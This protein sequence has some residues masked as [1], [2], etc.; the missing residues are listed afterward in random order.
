MPHDLNLKIGLPAT[1]QVM[2]AHDSYWFRL[3]LK[4][5]RRHSGLN[6]GPPLPATGQAITVSAATG[7]A[8]TGAIN[9]CPSASN[10]TA[11]GSLL[12]GWALACAVLTFA[13]CSIHTVTAQCP[14]SSWSLFVDSFGVEGNNSCVKFFTPSTG[15]SWSEANT[16]CSNLGFGAHLLTSRQV[17][18]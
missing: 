10:H 12:V 18:L 11:N 1:V 6:H 5:P 15:M 3:N 8:Q 9:G 13:V 7:K 14:D 17:R 16:A 2:T 4:L